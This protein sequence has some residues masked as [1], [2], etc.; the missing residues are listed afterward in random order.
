MTNIN[1]DLECA[2]G[3]DVHVTVRYEM[4]GRADGLVEVRLNGGDEQVVPG[5]HHGTLEAWLPLGTDVYLNIDREGAQTDGDRSLFVVNTGDVGACL[6]PPPTTTPAVPVPSAPP[7]PAGVTGQEV[8]P[9]PR[10]VEEGPQLPATG[11]ATALLLAI[12]LGLVAAGRGLRRLAR[13]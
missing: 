8:R 4:H 2:L 7:P 3:G 6:G 12:A 1:S 10:P 13:T 9:T 11:G 5:N